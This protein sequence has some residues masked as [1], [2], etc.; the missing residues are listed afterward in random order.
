MNKREQK[1][2]NVGTLTEGT[3]DCKDKEVTDE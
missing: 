3:E 1:N 2:S